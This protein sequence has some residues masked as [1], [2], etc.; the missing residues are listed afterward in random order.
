MIALRFTNNKNEKNLRSED[1]V[2]GV[3]FDGLC[4]YD[5]TNAINELRND[6]F[7]EDFTDEQLYMTVAIMQCKHDNWHA[8]NYDG[9]FVILSA[10]YSG[11]DRDNNQCFDGGNAKIAKNISYMAYGQ[12]DMDST[13]YAKKYIEMA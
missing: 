9:N 10:E 5:I 11:E 12:I 8:K 13:F 1:Q 4:V 2:N 6:P 3:M 7:Y